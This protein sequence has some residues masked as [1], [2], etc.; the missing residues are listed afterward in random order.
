MADVRGGGTALRPARGG[1]PARSR[2]R[3]SP[4]GGSDLGSSPRAAALAR[5]GH[6][7]RARPFAAP[8]ARSRLVGIARARRPRVSAPAA[9]DRPLARSGQPTASCSPRSSRPAELPAELERRVLEAAD[10][11]PF[12]LEE[13]VRSLADVGA[14]VRDGRRLALRPRGRGRGAAD[15][16]EGHPRPAR[17]PLRP[18]APSSSPP[19]P[20]SGARSRCRCSRACVGDVP[21]DS[22]HELQ[23]LGLLRQSRRWPQPE[24]RFRHALIQETAYR[25]LLGEQRTRPPPPRRGVARG[26]VRRARR[27]GA[28]PARA[29]LARGGGR[30]Q[31]RGLPPARAAT[32]LASSTHS[33]RRSSTTA[34]SSRSSSSAASARRS[35]SSSSSSRSRSTRRSASPRRTRRINVRSRTGLL[36]R[37]RRRRGR[38]TANRGE[39]RAARSRTRRTRGRVAGH[40]AL[41]AA[42]RPSRRSVAGADDRSLARR[43]VGDL[44]RRAPVRLP[45]LRGTHVVRRHA[46][47]RARCRVRHQARARP[48]EPGDHQSLSTSCWRTRR[49]MRW[50]A[51]ATPR[52]SAFARST[53]GRSSSG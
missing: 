26:A 6:A 44:G 22:L 39:L 52:A 53:T 50:A 1:R 27:R 34:R 4:L 9:R 45:P 12:F 21:A 36:R 43:A 8:G 16:G 33:T 32:R 38:D 15:G 13:L 24:F 7:G 31:G 37:R 51:H 46:A 35:R 42:L 30:G 3:G 41:H 19:R 5:R 10:G 11:N 17:P 49:T 40:R 25:T 48:R 28:R 20:R 29:P 18:G 2:V 23:R 47:D 14:L